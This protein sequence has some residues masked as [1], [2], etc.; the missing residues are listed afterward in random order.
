[1]LRPPQQ[2][3]VHPGNRASLKQRTEQG[4]IDTSAAVIEDGV[5]RA[6]MGSHREVGSLRARQRRVNAGQ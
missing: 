6:A 1:M 3:I 2:S 4:R 5:G